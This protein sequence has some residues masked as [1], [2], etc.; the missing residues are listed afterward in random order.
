MAQS[1][2][3]NPV[4]GMRDFLP[5]QLKTRNT[6]L[7]RIRETVSVR[8]FMEIETPAV[9]DIRRLRSKQGGANESMVFEIL[10]R[11]LDKDTPAKPG[12]CIDSGLRYDLTLPLSRYYA[13]NH[14]D[15]PAEVRIFQ[16]GP[17]WRAER[18]QRGRF[19]QFNQ[20]DIDIIG[21]TGAAAEVEVLST[22]LTVLTEL[23]LASR[24]TLHLNDRRIL[25][26]LMGTC[27]IDPEI[28]GIVL[29][30]LDKLDK[31]TPEEVTAAIAALEGVGETA[32]ASLMAAVGDLSEIVISTGAT[33]VSIPALTDPVPLFDIASVV[34][35][36]AD[37]NPGFRVVFDPSLV[38]GMGYYTGLIYE[39]KLDGES[40]SICGGGRYDGMIGRWLGKDVPAVGFS[41][42]FERIIGVVEDLAA[43]A[44]VAVALGYRT[45]ADHFAAIRLANVLT[46]QGKQVGLVKVPR[47]VKGTFFEELVGTYQSVIMPENLVLA[48]EEALLAAKPIGE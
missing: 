14:A 44:P 36:L 42:G 20:C 4:R 1:A 6:I 22:G 3:A 31:S 45:E 32:A 21:C 35:Q 16:T 13:N 30:E 37:L 40:S 33:E 12:D 26:H 18:P 43:T 8:G 28:R 41:F 46:G 48:P 25:D 39:V 24:A 34:E 38:R 7:A 47:K 19:R 23:G 15:L 5:S 27:G 10:K 11:G 29:V 9:E 2:S 17:V